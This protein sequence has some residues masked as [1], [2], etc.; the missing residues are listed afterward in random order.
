MRYA[1]SVFDSDVLNGHLNWLFSRLNWRHGSNLGLLGY[2]SLVRLLE[3]YTPTIVTPSFF[4]WC[5]EPMI[6]MDV[7]YCVVHTHNR[8]V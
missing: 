3:D 8:S 4:P 1:G 5:Y 2:N 7:T 6:V